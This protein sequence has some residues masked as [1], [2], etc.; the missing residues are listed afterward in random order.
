LVALPAFAVELKRRSAP[1][2]LLLCWIGVLLAAVFFWQYRNVTY[3][4][5]LAPAAAIL[6][7]AYG[8]LGEVRSAR[9]LLVLSLAAFAVKVAMP[10]APWGISFRGGTVVPSAPMLSQYCSRGR[11]NELVLVGF[12]DELYASVLP[13]PKARYYQIGPMPVSGRYGM[14]FAYMGIVLDPAQYDDLYRWLPLF[15][16]HLLE[17]GM[18]TTAPVGTMIAG[19][20]LADLAR[21]IQNH[22]ATDFFVPEGYRE[23]IAASAARTHELVSTPPGYFFLLARQTHPAPPPKWSCDP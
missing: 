3:L 14:D 4:L 9:W 8:T 15:R 18:D 5:P 16:R 11:A 22:P 21:T 13:L 23:M 7:T 17:W 2:V 12:D 10:G 20:T 19:A 6:A 1:A